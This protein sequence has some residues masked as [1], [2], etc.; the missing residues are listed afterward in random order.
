MKS[1]KSL[2]EVINSIVAEYA[3]RRFSAADRVRILARAQRKS[4]QTYRM[5]AEQRA[6]F[7]RLKMR[8]GAISRLEYLAEDWRVTNAMFSRGWL[9]WR[10][11]SGEMHVVIGDRA[12][13]LEV[14]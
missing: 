10:K 6:V 11:L 3:R 7:R 14:R 9:M 2:T 5:S 8:G 12:P 4:R 13:A 1:Q